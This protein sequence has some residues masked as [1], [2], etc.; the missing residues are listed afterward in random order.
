M[1]GM[2]TQMEKKDKKDDFEPTARPESRRI[3]FCPAC[4]R[5]FL[6]GM[7]VWPPSCTT[8][9]TNGQRNDPKCA[10]YCSE[11]CLPGKLA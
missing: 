3:A 4:G 2:S 10:E 11:E 6:R 8:N 7:G 1:C 5:P 9:P